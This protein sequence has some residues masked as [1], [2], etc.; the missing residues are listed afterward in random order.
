[1][2]EGTEEWMDSLMNEWMGESIDE[3][4]SV[5]SFVWYKKYA[6]KKRILMKFA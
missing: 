2:N 5:I 1:M 6:I 3:R 4:K